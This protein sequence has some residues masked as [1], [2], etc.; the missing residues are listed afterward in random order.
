MERT[1]NYTVKTHDSINGRETTEWSNFWYDQANDSSE[2][3]ILLIGDSTVRM[4]RSQF[5]KMINCPVDMLGTSSGL[6]DILFVEQ[7]NA[8]FVLLVI[9][10]M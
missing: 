1:M 5:A 7:V 3:R 2:H 9:N 6:H 10:G 8:F 4:V